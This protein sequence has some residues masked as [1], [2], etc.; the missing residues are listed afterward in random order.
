MIRWLGQRIVGSWR[1]RGLE[2]CRQRDHHFPMLKW[3][4]VV[5]FVPGRAIRLVA[6]QLLP[7]RDSSGEGRQDELD[8]HTHTHASLPRRVYQILSKHTCVPG[9][10][11]ATLPSRPAFRPHSTHAPVTRQNLGEGWEC[12]SAT[13]V[14][15]DCDGSYRPRY[16]QNSIPHGAGRENTSCVQASVSSLLVNT[17]KG[18][19]I[20]RNRV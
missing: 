7:H 18:V 6:I 14:Q 17:P 19:A 8:G 15:L 2:G 4:R 11:T 1:P 12:G 20:G 9:D 5:L 13:L 10:V 16:S 3:R